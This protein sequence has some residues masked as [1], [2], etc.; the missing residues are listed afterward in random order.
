MSEKE[1]VHRLERQLRELCGFLPALARDGEL[2]RLMVIYER[3]GKHMLDSENVQRIV[4]E[5]QEHVRAL[6]RLS[7]LLALEC[8]VNLAR[9]SSSRPV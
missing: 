4:A 6:R 1:K 8:Q 5:A 7:R 2:G 3:G 9:H